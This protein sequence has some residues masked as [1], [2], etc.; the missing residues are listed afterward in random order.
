MSGAVRDV[1]AIS[2]TAVLEH[3]VNCKLRLK[4]HRI[5]TV[6]V[7]VTRKHVNRIES[8]LM[9]FTLTTG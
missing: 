2:E 4:V 8:E 6:G 7:K 1:V 3:L 5:G 9:T